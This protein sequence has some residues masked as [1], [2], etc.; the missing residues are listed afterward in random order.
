MEGHFILVV[1]ESWKP[2]LE[3]CILWFIIYHILLLFVGSRARQ[4][5]L[6]ILILVVLFLLSKVMALT[7]LDWLLTKLF[8]IS[9]LAALIIFHPEIRQGLAR[10]GQQHFFSVAI[11]EEELDYIL[12]QVGKATDDLCKNKLGAIIAIENK[13]PLTVY[14]ES[15]VSVDARVSSELIETI[16][17][18]NTLLHDGGLIIQHGRMAAAGCIFPLTQNQDISRVFGTRHRAALGLSEETDA[19]IIIVSEERNDVSLVYESML[20]KDLSREE[21]F[22]KAKEF[23]RLRK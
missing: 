7:T 4:I 2:I 16:F 22:N 21:V 17:A 9:V 8:T 11:K 19:V 20:Y 12:K 18:P 6:G 1:L 14:L 13:D 23:L 5:F 3:I 15:G 10:L